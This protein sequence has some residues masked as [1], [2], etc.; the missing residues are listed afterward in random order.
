MTEINIILFFIGLLLFL[1]V[2]AS[3]LARFGP[4]LLLIFLVVGMLA[5][6]EGIGHIGFDNVPVAYFVASLA[7][8][9]ILL[10]GGLRTH[11]DTFRVALR[12]ALSLSTVGVLVSAALSGVFIA[13][14][15]QVDWRYGLLLGA[16]VASTDAAAVFAQLRNSGVALNQR[17]SATLEIESGTN[18]PMAIFLVT[19]LLGMIVD[20]DPFT[21][22]SVAAQL[23]M[24]FGIGILGG[25]VLGFGLAWLVS[26]LELVEGLYALLIVSGGLMAFTA[27]NQAGGSGFL[28]IYLVGLIVGNRPN[29]ATEHVFRVMDGLAWLSQ[30][31]MFLVLGLLVDPE[32]LL[33]HG[34]QALL[35]A[36]FL[37]FIARPAAVWLCLLPF[38]FPP[39]EQ[40]FIA[41]VGLRG[42]VPIVLSLFPMMENLS[43]A[44]FLF[45]ITFAVVLVSL[46][47]QGTSLGWMARVL[48]LQVPRAPQPDAYFA[49][50]GRRD[51][52]YALAAFR[53]RPA[54]QL[55]ATEGHALARFAGVR[56]IAVTRGTRLLFPKPQFVFAA[57]D[58]LYLLAAEQSLADLGRLCNGDL[59]DAL[60]AGRFFGSFPIR[61]EAPMHELAAVYGVAIDRER[62]GLSVGEYVR[63]HIRRRPVEGD[64]LDIDAI[65]LTV[66]EIRNGV[67]AGLGLQI[68]TDGS[69]L[70]LRRHR[71][72][73]KKK[74]APN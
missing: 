58:Q 9:V 32:Q 16:I 51:D 31:G 45:D 57:G 46:L 28:G 33:A 36:L 50:E 12:P 61:A 40:G 4:P 8:A 2:L 5:G 69:G 20:N 23:A 27:I 35:I 21:V 1:S 11:W 19:F 72:R 73:L 13:Y 63:A 10:D 67:I 37:I 26:R 22:S 59:R 56:C 64:T 54:S 29:H 6:R 38:H 52:D 41:W 60:P 48:K 18:D 49:L 70:A 68:R 15:L 34:G 3:A 7:L 43:G 55:A 44:Q 17:V 74:R 66:R 62:C 71:V 42:A 14:W 24:Q 30:A 25:I 47:V 53:I 65:R 39:R